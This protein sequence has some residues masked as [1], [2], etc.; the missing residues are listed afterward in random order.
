MSSTPPERP[1]SEDIEPRPSDVH[2]G[3]LTRRDRCSRSVLRPGNL[4]RRVASPRD[5]GRPPCRAF[6]SRSDSARMVGAL[7][8]RC[9]ALVHR[10]SPLSRASVVGTYVRGATECWAQIARWAIPSRWSGFRAGGLDFEKEPGTTGRRRR[11]GRG[12]RRA[13]RPRRRP[14][15][16][17]PG[18]AG[19]A[20][21]PPRLTPIRRSPG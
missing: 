19:E 12:P 16:G 8:H 14:R 15:C 6:P 10:W 13:P 7:V 11:D 4:L 2:D 21:R 17:C 9:D 5:H 18:H 3:R 1:S 20:T